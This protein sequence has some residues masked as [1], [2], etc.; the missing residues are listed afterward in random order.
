MSRTPR[1]GCNLGCGAVRLSFGVGISRPNQQ[2]ER[3]RMMKG[4][5]LD[6]PMRTGLEDGK[7]THSKMIHET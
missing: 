7:A 6:H 3:R 4:L 1:A 5:N 2:A